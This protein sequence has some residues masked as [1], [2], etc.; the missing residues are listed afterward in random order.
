MHGIA[1]PVFMSAGLRMG[2]DPEIKF[3]QRLP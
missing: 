2:A 3:M 1:K